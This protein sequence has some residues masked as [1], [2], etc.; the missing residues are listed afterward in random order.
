M[1]GERQIVCAGI[2]SEQRFVLRTRV[3]GTV[4]EASGELL[5]PGLRR[6]VGGDEARARQCRRTDEHASRK[7]WPGIRRRLFTQLRSVRFIDSLH[8]IISFHCWIVLLRCAIRECAVK[9]ACQGT[10]GTARSRLR[11]TSASGKCRASQG[12]T[13]HRVMRIDLAAG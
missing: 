5:R 6:R 10:R 3:A 8:W 13:G 4:S 7:G 12:S 11:A 9:R 1:V 2:L